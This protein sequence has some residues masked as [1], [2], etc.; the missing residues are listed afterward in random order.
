MC[1]DESGFGAGLGS[2]YPRSENPDMGHPVSWWMMRR[3]SNR[4]SPFDSL[5]TGELA[6]GRLSTSSAAAD[7]AQD[8][9]FW[10]TERRTKLGGRGSGRSYFTFLH[11][12][13][14]LA[15]RRSLT[16]VETS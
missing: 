10:G 13:M 6:Q 4:R 11:F 5:A 16:S 9:N 1:R 2:C 8:D 15:C 12:S 14:I 7:F 3:E